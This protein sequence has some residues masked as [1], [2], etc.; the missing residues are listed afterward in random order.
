MYQDWYVCLMTFSPFCPNNQ[1]NFSNIFWV[2]LRKWVC[3]VRSA[4]VFS[5]V[6]PAYFQNGWKL[7]LLD[8][9]WL[10]LCTFSAFVFVPHFHSKVC[11][12]YLSMFCSFVTLSSITVFFGWNSLLKLLKFYHFLAFLQ[13]TYI[14]FHTMP[15]KEHASPIS[16][17]L[18]S[19]LPS[20]K[21][22]PS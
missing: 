22:S 13:T 20:S 15:N 2:I 10:R 18:R 14:T 16:W 17:L 7:G 5:L 11:F 6:C 1:A 21:A 4:Y 3:D 9:I 19:M 12:W 8:T